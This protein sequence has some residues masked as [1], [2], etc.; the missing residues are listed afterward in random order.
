MTM[1]NVMTAPHIHDVTVTLSDYKI[2]VTKRNPDEELCEQS[3][4]TFFYNE[5]YDTNQ[6]VLCRN[7]LSLQAV[8]KS[9]YS[10]FDYA[11]AHCLSHVFDIFSSDKEA[12]DL[13]ITRTFQV[14][15]RHPSKI[16]RYSEALK[17]Y[18]LIII[19]YF[20]KLYF[21]HLFFTYKIYYSK[22]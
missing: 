13:N 10:K 6:V 17:D 18:D 14:N 22:K 9:G 5:T 4:R 12:Q 7:L 3:D 11:R 21:L 1:F 20:L 2:D 15:M 8:M 19:M 16:I